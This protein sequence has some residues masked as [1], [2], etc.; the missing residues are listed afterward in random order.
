[1]NCIKCGRAMRHASATGMGPKCARKKRQPEPSL[2][3]LDYTE[4]VNPDPS[5]AFY[6]HGFT[7]DAQP[8]DLDRMCAA[9]MWS[10]NLYIARRASEILRQ[11]GGTT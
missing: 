1:M 8:Y 10:V 4:P 5:A 9:A 11:L 2:F 6:I 3:A 7:T